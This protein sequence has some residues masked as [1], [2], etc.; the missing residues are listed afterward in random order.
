MGR[1]KGSEDGRCE[2]PILLVHVFVVLQLK[3]RTDGVY[4]LRLL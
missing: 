1:E 4:D 2:S 3:Q